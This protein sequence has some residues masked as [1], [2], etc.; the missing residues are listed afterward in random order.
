MRNGPIKIILIQAGKYDYAEVD[1]DSTLQI[2]GGNNVGKTTLINTLPFLYVDD[3]S[4]M[5]FGRYSLDQTLEYYFRSQYSYVLFECRTLRGQAVIGW[6]GSS[7]QSG[8]DP[9]RFCYLGPYRREHFF[10]EKGRVRDPLDVSAALALHE[11]QFTPK[12]Q[13]HREILLAGTGEHGGGLGIVS[14]KDPDKFHHF[15]ETLKNLLM[16]K[17]ISQ[18][19]MRDSLLMLADIPTDQPALEKRVVLGEDHDRLVNWRQELQRFKQHEP[20]IKQ[21]LEKFEACLQL[22]GELMHRWTV[23]KRQKEAFEAAHRESVAAIDTQIA[24]SVTQQSAA[25]ATLKAKREERDA[26]IEKRTTLKN[27]LDPLPALAKQF[28]GFG[29]ELEKAALAELEKRVVQK[30]AL[31]SEAATEKLANVE[32]KMAE[33]ETKITI[34]QQSIQQFSQL[35]VTAL[36]K[37]FSDEELSRIF[38]IINSELL[39]SPLGRKGITYSDPAGAVARLRQILAR[40]R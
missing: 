32:E 9:Q 8:G 11:L 19:Q 21:L 1:L 29:E 38:A 12:P 27:N 4:K 10:A 26:L 7:P 6:R 18:E 40:T 22:R 3:R 35:V 2:V 34:K 15:R 14:L 39:E 23:L 17:D 28:A 36:R 31:L 24:E 25:A 37:E 13:Q 33:A 16:L 20:V 30:Q 5:S